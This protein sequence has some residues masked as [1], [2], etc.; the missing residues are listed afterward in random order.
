[1]TGG[2]LPL[3]EQITELCAQLDRQVDEF[4]HQECSAVDAK[5]DYEVAYAKAYLSAAGTVEERTQQARL[6]TADERR[7]HDLTSAK[8]RAAREAI[9]ATHAR[10]DAARTL[11][12]NRREEVRNA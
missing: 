4:T 3:D 10:L 11:A 5:R 7:N 12:A 9:R 2:P 6:A 1:M 8:V